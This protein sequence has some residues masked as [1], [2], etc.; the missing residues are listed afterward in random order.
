[1]RQLRKITRPHGHYLACA[2]IAALLSA[3]TA[4]SAQTDRQ[5]VFVG[6]WKLDKKRSDSPAEM[7]KALEMPWYAHAAAATFTPTL[8]ISAQGEVLHVVS[9]LVLGTRTEEIHPDRLERPGKD[10][11]GRPFTETSHWTESRGIEI[12]R[13]LTLSDSEASITASWQ[14]NG[15]TLA[16][17]INVVLE[18]DSKIRVKRVFARQ[19]DD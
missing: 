15:D 18:D 16:T 11:L 7:M 4:T 9:H 6:R 2:L 14:A 12:Q 17:T 19:R 13:R 1:M 8:E 3:P 5:Q 10:M